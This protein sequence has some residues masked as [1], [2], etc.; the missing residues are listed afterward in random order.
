MNRNLLLAFICLGL[1]AVITLAS[2]SNVGFS[3]EERPIESLSKE[4]VMY[5]ADEAVPRVPS[6]IKVYTI[7]VSNS[8]LPRSY[9]VPEFEGCFYDSVTGKAQYAGITADNVKRSAFSRFGSVELGTG[10]TKSIGL[11]LEAMPRFGKDGQ[12]FDQLLLLDSKAGCYDLMPS[13][14]ESAVKIP[15]I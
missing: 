10:E 3:V 13:D 8:F 15:I 9:P 5:S 6:R 11:Y 4:K 1:M 2:G 14:I 7:T 12:E